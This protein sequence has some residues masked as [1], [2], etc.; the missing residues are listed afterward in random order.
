MFRSEVTIYFIFLSPGSFFLTVS[1]ALPHKSSSL[2]IVIKKHRLNPI[3]SICS[4]FHIIFCFKRGDTIEHFI[5]K[6]N[7]CLQSIYENQRDGKTHFKYS[8]LYDCLKHSSV[9]DELPCLMI[10]LCKE[11]TSSCKPSSCSKSLL[12]GKE[13]VSHNQLRSFSDLNADMSNCIITS[14]CA[15]ISLS[16]HVDFIIYSHHN[17]QS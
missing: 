5:I 14:Y 17:H 6:R 1:K 3:I 7:V 13:I 12:K 15:D 11:Q 4:P 8:L 10:F 2:I 16:G 9:N